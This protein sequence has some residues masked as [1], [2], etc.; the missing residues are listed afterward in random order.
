MIR[1]RQGNSVAILNIS[2][3]IITGISVA[4]AGVL[5]VFSPVNWRCPACSRYL[6]N[7]SIRRSATAAALH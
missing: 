2:S 4:A 1:R 5:V 7:E 6:S 3:D